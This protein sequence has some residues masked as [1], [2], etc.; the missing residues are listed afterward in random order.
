MKLDD[1]YLDAYWTKDDKGKP[2]FFIINEAII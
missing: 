2:Q 1:N